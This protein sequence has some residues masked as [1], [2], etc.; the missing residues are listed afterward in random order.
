MCILSKLHYAMSDVPSLLCSN[1]IEE[2]P[3]GVGSTPLG[4]GRVKGR[5]IIFYQGGYLFHK[6]I[7]CKL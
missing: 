6:K 7:V 5:T 1:V 4:K 3:L 2:K